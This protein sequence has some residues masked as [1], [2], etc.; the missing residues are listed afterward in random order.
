MKAMLA[1]TLLVLAGAVPVYATGDR[2][3]EPQAPRSADPQVL[4]RADEP[5]AP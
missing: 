1:L 5:E 3:D 2:K 4:V